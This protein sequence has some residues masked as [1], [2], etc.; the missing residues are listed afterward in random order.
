VA[1]SLVAPAAVAKPKD[2]VLDRARYAVGI[3]QEKAKANAKQ[4]ADE[5][6]G[7]EHRNQGL[8]RAETAI[9]EAAARKAARDAA[10]ENGD[11]PGRG[12]GRGHADEV[13]AILL[14][15][16][17][18]PSQL[19]SRGQSVQDLAHAYQKVKANHPGQGNAKTDKGDDDTEGDDE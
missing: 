8:A 16:D 19:A 6:P 13:H 1:V 9:G 14:L 4:R 18:S 12:L 10:K 3:G 7:Q 11:K 17:G 2:D 5:A 15:G